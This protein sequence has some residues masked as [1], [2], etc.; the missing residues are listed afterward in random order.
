MVA[1]ILI[2]VGIVALKFAFDG[3]IKQ[4]IQLTRPSNHNG[5]EKE[6]KYAEGRRAEIWGFVCLILGI[7]LVV[8]GGLTFLNSLQTPIH[9]R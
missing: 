4:R 6:A 1:L 8:V 5:V 9:F 2:V 3:I 7:G